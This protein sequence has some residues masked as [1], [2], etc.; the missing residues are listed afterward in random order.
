MKVKQPN[1]QDKRILIYGH[2]QKQPYLHLSE[3]SRELQI[4]KTT[5]I[6]HLIYLEKNGSIISKKEGRYTRYCI[7]NEISNTEKKIL[8]ILRQDTTR[9]VLL[10]ISLSMGAS[11][12]ELAKELEKN[13]KT[14]QFHLKK[15]LD[16]DIIEVAPVDKVKGIIYTA[17]EPTIIYRKP[18]KNEVFYRIKDPRKMKLH[19]TSLKYYNKRA[20]N[21]FFTELCVSYTKFVSPGEGAP[22]IIKTRKQMVET[23]EKI[24]SEVFP[25]P[26]YG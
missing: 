18:C 19:K 15:L 7:V 22:K 10:Y 23:F 9:D 16:L 24:L 5:L 8:N 6:H 17:V 21:D 2:I 12:I 3:L 11:Q 25:H 4:P 26:Y 1:K 14:I 13:P 20:I